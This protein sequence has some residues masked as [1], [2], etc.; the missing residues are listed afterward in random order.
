MDN[1]ESRVKQILTNR[2]G[3]PAEQIGNDVQL[4][5]LGLDSLDGV[6][7]A[8]ALEHEFD[9]TVNDRQIAELRTVADIIRL[10]GQGVEKGRAVPSAG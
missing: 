5:E 10:A 4:L 2:L 3:M 7:L 9:I 8:I 1:I 6:E